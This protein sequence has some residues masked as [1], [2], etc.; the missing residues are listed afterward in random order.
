VKFILNTAVDP[1]FCAMFSADNE[2]LKFHSWT[3]RRADGH[4]VFDFLKNFDA[5][6]I[7]FAGGVAGPGGFSSLRAAAGILNAIA[8]AAEIPVH[9][10]RADHWI[11]AFLG[12]ENFLLNSF[13]SAVWKIKNGEIFRT[14]ISELPKKEFFTKLLPPE[15]SEKI[16]SIPGDSSGSEK[17][18]LS[19]L[20]KTKPQD[21]FHPDYEFPPV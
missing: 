8:F 20:E 5:K 2:I 18:L 21:G 13:G 12:H 11:S 1:H 17:T 9:Q 6:K 7:T 19:V 3:D 14:E 15:K 10:I 16:S 4:E